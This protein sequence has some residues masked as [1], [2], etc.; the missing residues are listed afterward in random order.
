MEVF[1]NNLT[2]E[3]A[4]K[5]IYTYSNQLVLITSQATSAAARLIFG[6]LAKAANISIF[7]ESLSSVST[8]IVKFSII[9]YNLSAVPWSRWDLNL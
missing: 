9:G 8:L 7:M 2:E 3:P 6:G 1:G 5:Q 4:E